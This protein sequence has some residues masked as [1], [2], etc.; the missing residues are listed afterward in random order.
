MTGFFG[1]TT[2]ESVSRTSMIR[3]AQTAARG[4][5]MTIIVAI[6]TLMRICIR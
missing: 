1:G 2:V 5:M 4:T 6:I 3:S